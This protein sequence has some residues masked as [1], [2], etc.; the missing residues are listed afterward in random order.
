MSEELFEI[1]GYEGLY[2]ITKSGKIW[3]HEKLICRKNNRNYKIKAK[4]LKLSNCN[5]YRIVSLSKNKK[6]IIFYVHRLVAHAFISNPLNKPQINHKNLIKD[7]NRA[8]NLEWVTHK[9]NNRHAIKNGIYPLKLTKKQM[10]H[11]RINHIPIISFRN[12]QWEQYNISDSTYYRIL[13]KQGVR[14]KND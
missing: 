14:I 4:W 9:E 3:G 1:K 11:L 5:G 10:N 8:E 2:S 12:K 7:D 6:N 13:N